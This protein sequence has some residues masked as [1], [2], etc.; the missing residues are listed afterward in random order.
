[1]AEE[2]KIGGESN[3][4]VL[5]LYGANGLW[6]DVTAQALAN[7]TFLPE[8]SPPNAGGAHAAEAANGGKDKKKQQKE[9]EEEK[10]EGEEGAGYLLAPCDDGVRCVL[11]GGD[12]FLGVVKTLRVVVAAGGG[13]FESRAFAVRSSAERSE[14]VAL[15][16]AALPYIRRL[17]VWREAPGARPA[18]EWAVTDAAAAELRATFSAERRLARLHARLRLVSPRGAHFL[19]E[20]PEQRMARRFV[21][22]DASGVLELGGNVGRNSVVIAALLDDD[23]RLVTFETMPADAAHLARNR[24]ANG[25]RFHIECAALSARKLVQ[26]GWQSEVLSPGKPVPPGWTEVATLSWAQ[27][28]AK[29][30]DIRFDTLVADCEGALYWILEDAPEILDHMHTVLIENDFFGPNA[31][32]HK[33]AV[34]AHFVRAGLRRVYH[35]PMAGVPP[36]SASY[37]FEAWQRAPTA[38]ATP[39]PAAATHAAAPAPVTAHA[40]VTA[41]PAVAPQAV[42]P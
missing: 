11:L 4:G 3:A 23:R 2:R 20:Y 35:L 22:P 19:D 14:Y 16:P 38:A 17:R 29:Y 21:R 40:A 8:D 37:F 42:T 24:D 39:D 26:K 30:P 9:E 18:P 7:C 6:K 15:P 32:A 28:R 36:P 41:P 31:L 10:E 27:V 25:Q 12:P 13:G 34:D 5:V 33:R 1:M